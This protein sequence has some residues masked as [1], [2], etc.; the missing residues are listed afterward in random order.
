MANIMQVLV[1]PVTPS[2]SPCPG[3][4]PALLQFQQHAQE[5]ICV[6]LKQTSPDARKPETKGSSGPD[7]LFSKLFSLIGVFPKASFFEKEVE[8]GSTEGR[9]WRG[10]R[11]DCALA[12]AGL[13]PDPIFKSYCES[14][15]K[16]WPLVSQ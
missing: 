13:A 2:R 9:R 5:L 7:G 10:A 1:E 12:P 15:Q 6:E 3:K 4:N 16:R 11:P 8:H 14:V